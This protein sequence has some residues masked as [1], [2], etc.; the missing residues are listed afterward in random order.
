MLVTEACSHFWI[1]QFPTLSQPPMNALLLRGEATLI[2]SWRC[3]YIHLQVFRILN[4][5]SSAQTLG[6]VFQ[7]DLDISA[8]GVLHQDIKLIVTEMS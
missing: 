7:V 2:G 6:E 3:R 4:P 5:P 1:L 8:F